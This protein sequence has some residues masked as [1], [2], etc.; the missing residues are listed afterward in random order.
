V[1]GESIYGG[2]RAYFIIDKNEQVDVLELG[3]KIIN[4]WEGFFRKHNIQ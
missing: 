1:F 3:Q 2:G 4:L